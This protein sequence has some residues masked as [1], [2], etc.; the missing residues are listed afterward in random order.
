[1]KAPRFQSAWVIVLPGIALVIALMWG[2]GEPG[3]RGDAS[4]ARGGVETADARREAES[5]SGRPGKALQRADSR[6][7]EEFVGRIRPITDF[8]TVADGY[9]S[10]WLQL[11]EAEKIGAEGADEASYLAL[12]GRREAYAYFLGVR[13]VNPEWKV[14]MVQARLAKTRG[15]LEEAF[16]RHYPD[17]E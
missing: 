12:A 1:M 5:D 2:G 3:M 8:D 9:F 14:D 17:A 15:E 7:F 11:K 4:G 6:S 10:G 16:R 13:E